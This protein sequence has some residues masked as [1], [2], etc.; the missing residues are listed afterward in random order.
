MAI[1]NYTYCVEWAFILCD[2]THLFPV[3]FLHDSC[4]G[5]GNIH[6]AG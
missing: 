5:R 3:E 6:I 4:N 2:D 1:Y